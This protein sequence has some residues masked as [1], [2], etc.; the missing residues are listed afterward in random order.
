[1]A[2]DSKHATLFTQLCDLDF[3][4]LILSWFAGSG[5]TAAIITKRRLRVYYWIRFT[6]FSLTGLQDFQD[7]G[8][9]ANVRPSPGGRGFSRGICAGI[10]WR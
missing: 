9:H 8:A 4:Q 2:K 5:I 6:E 3:S 10:S 1:V 7:D